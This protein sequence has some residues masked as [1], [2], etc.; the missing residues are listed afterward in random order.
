[1]AAP[2]IP[3]YD[4]R[5]LALM[6]HCI[7]TRLAQSQKDFLET[8]GFNPTNLKQVRKPI[9]ERGRQSF[10]IDHMMAACKKYKVSM[11]WICGFTPEMKLARNWTAVE[12]LD[13]ALVAVKAELQQ[14]SSRTQ[15]STQRH[16]K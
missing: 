8:I 16:K 9:T 1:M 14:V 4:A 6:R 10:T 2:K 5:M 13:A 11:D 3:I 7:D 12:M 15:K